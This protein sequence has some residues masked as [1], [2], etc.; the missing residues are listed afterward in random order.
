[1][2][3]EVTGAPT[4]SSNLIYFGLLFLFLRWWKLADIGRRHRFDVW[5]VAGCALWAYILAE[6]ISFPSAWGAGLAAVIAASVQLAS[7]RIEP[8]PRHY[9]SQAA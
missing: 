5:S 3:F 1:V 9:V 8:K 4:I 2:M 6:V 7:P